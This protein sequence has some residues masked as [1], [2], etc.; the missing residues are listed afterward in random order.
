MSTVIQYDV[1]TKDSHAHSIE[2][3]MKTNVAW[4]GEES[5]LGNKATRFDMNT[6]S[7]QEYPLLTD[8]ARPHTGVVTADGTYYVALADGVLPPKLASVDPRNR[9]GHAIQLAGKENR[10][11]PYH[12][13]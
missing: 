5:F 10:R 3:D 2:I 1:P 13:A 9:K 4:F 11:G 6:E 12:R 7:F 8:K